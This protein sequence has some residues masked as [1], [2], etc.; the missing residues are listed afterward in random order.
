MA[1]LN[2]YM[3]VMDLDALTDA[4]LSQVTTN[5]MTISYTPLNYPPPLTVYAVN[6]SYTR[7]AV[8]HRRKYVRGGADWRQ[9]VTF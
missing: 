4:S 8:Y 3:Y 1:A 7:A 9:E 2:L 6:P 5:C